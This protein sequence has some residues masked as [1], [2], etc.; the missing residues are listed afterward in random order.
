MFICI[1]KRRRNGRSGSGG[2]GGG[3][4]DWRGASEKAIEKDNENKTDVRMYGMNVRV[5]RARFRRRCIA[6]V[7]HMP[8]V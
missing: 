2:G 6:A 4:R 1:A 5:S 7:I 3:D 8:S